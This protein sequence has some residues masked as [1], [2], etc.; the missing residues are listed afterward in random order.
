[1]QCFLCIWEIF[2]IQ[3]QNGYNE[4]TIISLKN[5]YEN[6]AEDNMEVN[7]NVI[8]IMNESYADL[9]NLPNVTYSENPMEIINNIESTEENLIRGN[10][11][12]PVI[13][14]G[15][16]LPE[17]EALTGLTSYFIEQQIF[18]YTSYIRKDMNSIVRTF[19]E[20]NYKTVGIHTNTKTFYNRYNIYKYLGFEETIFEEDIENPEYKGRYISDDEAADQIIKAFEGHNG[21]KFIFAVTMQNHMPYTGVNY[22]KYD[23]DIESNLLSSTETI[24][25]KNY[26]QG[27]YDANKMYQ[28][29]VEYLKE[30]EE[31]T[32]LVMF[33]DHLPLLGDS[34]A[35]TYK[36]NNLSYLEYYSTP[37]IIWANYD[38]TNNEIPESLS[39]SNLGLNILEMANIEM[40]WYLKPFREL[41]NKYPAINNKFILDNEGKV[42]EGTNVDDQEL[43]MDCNILQYDLL[44]KKKYINVN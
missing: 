3:H 14:G 21:N 43:I 8:L 25:L 11:I 5:E 9:S 15:T 20:N 22:E 19:R 16:S 28:K 40:P 42:I 7:P 10:M 29:L 27:V 37:Y 44:I 2:I 35:A 4:E 17:F 13:G 39:A 24:E 34:Y 26:T 32:I 30:Q 36:K 18:P 6:L 1:M 41:Y 33:G 31:P 12:S 38:I 23:I